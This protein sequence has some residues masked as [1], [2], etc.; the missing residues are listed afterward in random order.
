MLR[1]SIIIALDIT[2]ANIRCITVEDSCCDQHVH[3]LGS[4]EDLSS[5]AILYQIL[6][7]DLTET[8]IGELKVTVVVDV[9]IKF[10]Q[11]LIRVVIKNSGIVN[12][13]F[14]TVVNL[15]TQS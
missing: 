9:G 13:T 1:N 3:E 7:I 2:Q 8:S 4:L 14:D 10:G 5:G 11:F 12:T 6:I 15:L